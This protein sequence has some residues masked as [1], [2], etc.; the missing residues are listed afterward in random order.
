MWPF[1]DREGNPKIEP[2]VATE[3]TSSADHQDVRRK[4]TP[5]VEQQEGLKA[6]LRPSKSL[7]SLKLVPERRGLC[8][9]PRSAVS[10]SSEVCAQGEVT[11][12]PRKTETH[13]QPVSDQTAQEHEQACKSK[14]EPASTNDIEESPASR[15][16]ALTTV[17]VADSKPMSMDKDQEPKPVANAAEGEVKQAS[18]PIKKRSQSSEAMPVLDRKEPR[19]PMSTPAADNP[20]SSATKTIQNGDNGALLNDLPSPESVQSN[21]LRPWPRNNT[22][23]VE[24]PVLRHPLRN[25][26]TT[27][28]I[29]TIHVHQT[30]E[31][32]ET[33]LP[34]RD[35]A[36]KCSE[37]KPNAPREPISEAPTDHSY[38]STQTL[39]GDPAQLDAV[40]HN[41][42]A[43]VVRSTAI[44]PELPEIEAPSA[45]GLSL[46][47]VK[48]SVE[49]DRLE[50]AKLAVRK[51][52][53]LAGHKF[54]LSILLG[55][56]LAE[57][58]KPQ[59]EELARPSMRRPGKTV[60]V[61]GPSQVDGIAELEGELGVP[62]DG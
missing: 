41:P 38:I 51:A 22:D 56:R 12:P 17:S 23:A 55:R 45:I 18:A 27:A 15:E 39:T 24:S 50:F 47:K 48:G 54:V 57:Q 7:T 35:S 46:D 37:T 44:E 21:W 1:T 34:S 8:I 60:P 59:L 3:D 4:S 19:D 5:E 32:E 31:P 53:N 30:T 36:A 11:S 62:R 26:S 20:Q 13:E 29:P 25:S 33:E 52:R 2:L 43:C 58:T 42:A 14:R 61:P 16:D 40:L 6:S 9:P 28:P 10:Q 49:P